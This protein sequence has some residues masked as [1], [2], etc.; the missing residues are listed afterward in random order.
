MGGRII[1]GARERRFGSRKV[2]QNEANPGPPSREEEDW[3]GNGVQ[4][5]GKGRNLGEGKA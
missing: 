1:T 2:L 4:G 5:N 3:Q